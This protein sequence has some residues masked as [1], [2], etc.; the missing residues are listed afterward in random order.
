MRRPFGFPFLLLLPLLFSL[1]QGTP[2]WA[3][4]AMR[5][6]AIYPAENYHTLGAVTF[7]QK[8]STYTDG[9]V[10]ID[11]VPDGGLGFKGPELLHA[12][13][14]GEL[15]LSDV[16]MG[17]VASTERA[18]GLSSLPLLARSFDHA[19]TL[20]EL[21]RPLY[22]SLCAKWGVVFLYAAPWPPSGLYTKAPVTSLDDLRGLRIRT[23]DTNGAGLFARLGATPVALPWSDLQPA[24]RF[25][26]VEAVLTSTTSGEDGRLH[27]AFS[28]F[29][30]LGYAFPLNMMIMND[31]SWARLDLDQKTA[32]RRA[33]AETQRDLWKTARLEHERGMR[34]ITAR[35]ITVT[36]PDDELLDGIAR[37][38][39]A[40]LD[41]FQWRAGHE[42]RKVIEAFRKGR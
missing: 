23:Y 39:E 28:H 40:I 21:A 26:T 30:D 36:A 11:V 13:S 31:R 3:D 20:Y 27:T 29:L 19:R 10:N 15:V 35:G 34:T 18:F 37:N 16:L 33:A 7:A 2:A 8:V 41:E 42:A 4:H 17:G 5:L 12:V 38:A 1:A 14:A 24:L 9:T 22:E 6:N 32:L 25:E